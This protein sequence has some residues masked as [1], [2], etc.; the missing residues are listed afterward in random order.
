MQAVRILSFAVLISLLASCSKA[1]QKEDFEKWANSQAGL[2]KIK[3][4]AADL[5]N[6]MEARIEAIAALVRN[7]HDI[8]VR[9]IVEACGDKE[10]LASGISGKFM[11]GL[12]NPWEAAGKEEEAAIY[13]ARDTV[14]NMIRF[15]NGAEREAVQKAVAEWAFGAIREDEGAEQVRKKIEK[16]IL[17][18]QIPELEAHGV[19][20]AVLLIRNGFVIEKMFSYLLSLKDIAISLKALDAVK[21][22]HSVPDVMI[23]YSH[24]DKIGEIEHPAAIEYLLDISVNTQQEKDIR[25]YAFNRASDLIEKDAVRKN[26]DMSGIIERL[27]KIIQKKSADDRW[28]PSIMILNLEGAKALDRVAAAFKDDHVYPGGSE[29]PMKSVVDICKAGF[30]P[31]K[32]RTDIFAFI[33]KLLNGGNRVQKTI[34]IVCLK[35]IEDKRGLAELKKLFNNRTDLEDVLGEKTTLGNLARNAAEG[36]EMAKEVDR[37]LSSGALKEKDAEL[38]KF[39]ILVD[40]MNT[41]QAYRDL[42]EERFKSGK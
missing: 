25:A 23:A 11:S 31:L 12:K 14:I 17:I 38:R 32:D 40:L 24:I 37:A 3:E 13:K 29:D 7:N 26:Y 36:I 21:K 33:V 4:F 16:T 20:G 5:K 30:V 2:K 10:K 9:E 39:Y 18:N 28:V 1:P 42:V 35:A 15:L 34:A 27:H 6:P 22:L 8:L 19:A 41:G